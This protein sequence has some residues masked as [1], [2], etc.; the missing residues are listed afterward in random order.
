M[1]C[2]ARPEYRH[3]GTVQGTTPSIDT[4]LLAF[5]TDMFYS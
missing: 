1:R 3:G 4:I 2:R 5:Y